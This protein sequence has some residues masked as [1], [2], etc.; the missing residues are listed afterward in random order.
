MHAVNALLVLAL[1]RRVSGSSR[2]AWW[3]AALF[4]TLPVHVEAVAYIKNL[5][6]LQALTF[7][8]VSM[9]AYLG[10]DHRSGGAA[11]PGAAAWV[12]ATLFGVAVFTKESAFFAPWACLLAAWWGMAGPRRRALVRLLP[13]VAVALLYVAVQASVMSGPKPARTAWPTPLIPPLSRVVLVGETLVEYARLI[14]L[15]TR[16]APWRPLE[17]PAFSLAALVPALAAVAGLALLMVSL[18]RRRADLAWWLGLGVLA[19]GPALNLVVNAGRLIAEQRAYAPSLALAACLGGGIEA[20]ARSRRRAALALGLA[21]LASLLPVTWTGATVYGGRRNLWLTAVRAAPRHP[22][23]RLNLAGIYRQSGDGRLAQPERLW[24]TQYAPSEAW[25]LRHI[26]PGMVS[27]EVTSRETG[28]LR[29]VVRRRPGDAETWRSLG[30][31]YQTMGLLQ[32][33]LDGYDQAVRLRPAFA[34]ALFERGNLRQDAGQF[35]EAENDYRAALEAQPDHAPAATNLGYLLLLAGRAAEAEAAFRRASAAR[36]DLPQAMAG[37]G[38]ALLRLGRPAEA[39]QAMLA[40]LKIRP[41]WVELWDE[42]ALAFRRSGDTARAAWAR[43][44]DQEEWDKRVAAGQAAPEEPAGLDWFRDALR[45]VSGD[46]MPA[47][48]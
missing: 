42:L 23:A 15:F 21:L 16:P 47:E 3:S 20:L 19:L 46:G 43:Q 5:G 1:V 25:T 29:E 11:C 28:R 18:M 4:A 41:Q 22:L 31:G 30:R 24:A 14:C 39:A 37:R 7:A 13:M 2:A 33:A 6:E 34:A 26:V 8:L 40:A 36:P 44:R 35:A 17:V 9:L 27:Y 45:P 38:Q 32:E 48:P 10:R 12:S